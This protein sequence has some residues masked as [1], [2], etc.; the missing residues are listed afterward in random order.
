[1]RLI[2]AD[3]LEP[4]EVGIDEMSFLAVDYEDIK[5]APTIEPCEDAISRADVVEIAYAY[6]PDDDGSCTKGDRD[7]RELLDDL[8]A[9]PSVAPSRPKGEWIPCSKDG[10]ALTELMRREGQKWYGYKCSRCNEIYKGN[11]LLECNFCH[12]CGAKM[13]G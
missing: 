8:E 10:L 7:I 6:C 12:N 9:L 5:N 11:A 13:R 1:M 2:D 4:I 3:K